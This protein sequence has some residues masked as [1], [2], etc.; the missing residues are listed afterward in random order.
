MSRRKSRR[1]GGIQKRGRQW[2]T[3]QEIDKDWNLWLR[4]YYKGVEYTCNI[5]FYFTRL[6]N[7]QRFSVENTLEFEF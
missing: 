2:E 5:E 7:G 3:D 4:S 1:E 6:R